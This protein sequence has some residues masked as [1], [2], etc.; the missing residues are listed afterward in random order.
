MKK[1][2]KKQKLRNNEYYDF[3]DT[4]DS[5]YAK[6]NNNQ[7]FQNLMEY[8][9]KGENILLAYRNIKKNKGSYTKGVDG[10]TIKYFACMTSEDVI[11]Y[12]RK[13]LDNYFPQ[14][15]RRIEIPKADG[16]TRPLG[17][18]TI[19][20]R[21][22]QQCILQVLEPICEAKFFKHSYG[23]RPLRSTKHAIARAYFLAQVVHLHHVVDIDIKSFFDTIN[24]GKLLKQL[25]ELGICDKNL[26][27]I[28]SKM[29]K[30]EIENI[31]IPT[32]GT[33]QGGILSPLLSNVV[34]NEL[35]WWIANQWEKHPTRYPYKPDKRNGS[36]GH[37]Y[38]VLKKTK[39][40]EVF[41]VRYADDF[42][43]F[44]R[45]RSHAKKIFQATQQWL[46]ER[47]ALK[48]SQE[49]S[50]ITNLKKSYSDF[51]GIKIKV[52]PRRKMADQKPRF[53]AISHIADKAK[54]NILKKV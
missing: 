41:I 22:I 14:K 24:H 15:V 38:E 27:K 53:V 30:A 46:Y 34:L 43:I 49:K 35:D 28:L 3:Q 17:I 1:N 19:G 20:D 23:F 42:K 33:P 26:L 9:R 32:Q 21:L 8:I 54:E 7:T 47:L 45:Y 13:K 31:G 6:S 29:L 52:K 25:W 18:P 39:L 50:K 40:K 12:V 36:E 48:I 44:C 10:R 16:R 37:K 51:L 4:L 11:L 2:L 5:L